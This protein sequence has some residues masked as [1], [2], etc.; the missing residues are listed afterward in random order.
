LISKFPWLFPLP[1]F[2]EEN[3]CDCGTRVNGTLRVELKVEKGPFHLGGE[4][5]MSTLRDDFQQEAR[6][7][8]SG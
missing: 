1:V 3:L 6:D 2:K 7:G 4:A 5:R 8:N